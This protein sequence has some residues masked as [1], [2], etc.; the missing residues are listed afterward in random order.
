M[1]SLRVFIVWTYYPDGIMM[2]WHPTRLNR[3]DNSIGVSSSS[4]MADRFSGNRWYI[5]RM[6]MFRPAKS[7]IITGIDKKIIFT[8]VA[9]GAI[10]DIDLLPEEHQ[11]TLGL[12]S[13]QDTYS[14]EGIRYL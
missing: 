4:G 11:Y 7:T 13:S 10:F 8:A 1:T 14:H 3:R 5:E 2:A 9:L 6:F 12:L